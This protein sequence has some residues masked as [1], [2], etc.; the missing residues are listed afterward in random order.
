MTTYNIGDI[1][2]SFAGRSEGTL[3]DLDDSGATMIMFYNRPTVDEIA[4]FA[5]SKPFEIR[6]TTMYNIMM[7]TARV[8]SLPW[9][10]MPFTPHISRNLTN[11]QLPVDG[12]G[13][14]L[15]LYLVDCSNGQIK[16]MRLLGLSDKFT[17]A[18]I[19]AA[20]DIKMQPFDQT[21]YNRNLQRIF[22]RY[23]TRQ[24]TDM[25]KDYCKFH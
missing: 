1:I 14:A 11:L 13:L 21:E 25:S 12:Q 10:D 15:M 7:L 8:G 16:S 17:R 4:Q 19:G 20:L 9:V 23:T 5:S 3:F 6:L 24:L 22:D 18:L 2:P